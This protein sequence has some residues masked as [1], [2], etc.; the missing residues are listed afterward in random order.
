MRSGCWLIGQ[1]LIYQPTVALVGIIFQD[2]DHPGITFRFRDLVV[3]PIDG[4]LAAVGI[5]GIHA[6]IGL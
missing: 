1:N 5:L 6:V 3:L 4:I 2:L